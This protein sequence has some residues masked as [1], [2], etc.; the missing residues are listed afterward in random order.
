MCVYEFIIFLVLV[1]LFV[2]IVIIKICPC[3]NCVRQIEM[4]AVCLPCE[5]NVSL[6]FSPSSFSNFS[7]IS[8][9]TRFLKSVDARKGRHSTFGILVLSKSVPAK[10]K[11]FL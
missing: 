8:S 3:Q 5:L 9:G 1:L 11:Y 4:A 10:L 6:R 2:L 7:N